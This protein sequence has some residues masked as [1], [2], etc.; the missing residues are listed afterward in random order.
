MAG[1]LGPEGGRRYQQLH[2]VDYA[3][4]VLSRSRPNPAEKRVANEE[5]LP[6]QALPSGMPTLRSCPDKERIPRFVSPG[7]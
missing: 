1:L 3:K 4:P 6:L 5:H 2:G 7:G